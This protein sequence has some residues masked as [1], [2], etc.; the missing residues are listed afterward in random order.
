MNTTLEEKKATNELLE[1]CAVYLN[2]NFH[3]FSQTNK[4]KI[5]L[6]IF[7][8]KLPMQVEGGGIGGE[9]RI[10]IIRDGNKTETLAGQVH[11]QQEEIPGA[12]VGLGYRKNSGL[13]LAGNVIQRGDS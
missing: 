3:K 9:T 8:R 6:E 7:K 12:V 13:N 2:G 5:S 4:I 10:I 11:L 1:K